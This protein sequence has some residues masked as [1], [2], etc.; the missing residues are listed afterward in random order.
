[1]GRWLSYAMSNRWTFEALG[2]DLGVE[3]LWA[4]GRSPL[5]PPLLAS[6]AGTFS[7]PVLADQ[8]ILA[9]FAALSLAAACAVVA[10]RT[11][12][13][14]RGGSPAVSATRSR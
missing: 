9:G 2:H 11:Q 7:R 1:V 8:V 3:R 12:H 13:R 6:Y 14:S 5:G 10:R 4:S